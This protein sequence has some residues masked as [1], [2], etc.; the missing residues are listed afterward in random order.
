VEVQTP[1]LQ[2]MR[3]AP[4][5]AEP[6][7]M[8]AAPIDDDHGHLVN[9]PSRRLMCVCRACQLLFSHDGAGGGRF[10]VVP[11]R[12]VALSGLLAARDSLDALQIPIGL[13]F[14]FRNSITG[15]TTAFYPGPAGATESELALDTWDRITAEVPLLATLS[16]DVEALLMR[17]HDTEDEAFIVPIDACY[18][19]VGRI[20][21]SWRGLQGGDEAHEVIDAFFTRVRERA[22]TAAA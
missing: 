7:D 13:A 9:V 4:R 21:R 11:D 20:R 5:P 8:C 17:R 3:A 1:L 16:P 18:E 22:M 6:C 15:R 14:F 10:R 2:I 12:Y 19:L